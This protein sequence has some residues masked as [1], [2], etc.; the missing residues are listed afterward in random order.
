MDMQKKSII[1]FF[2]K[3]DNLLTRSLRMGFQ[4]QYLLWI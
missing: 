1:W 4:K 3:T 2:H